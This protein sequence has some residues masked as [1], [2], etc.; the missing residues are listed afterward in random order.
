MPAF[1]PRHSSGKI[2]SLPR[3]DEREEDRVEE[4]MNGWASFEIHHYCFA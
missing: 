2:I 4:K 1:A 3:L